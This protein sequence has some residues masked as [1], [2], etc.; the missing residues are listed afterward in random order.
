MVGAALKGVALGH[1][2][3]VISG[4]ECLLTLLGGTM[5]PGIRLDL[6]AGAALDI[7]IAHRL[8]GR[9]SV[10]DLFLRDRLEQGVVALVGIGSPQ[11]CVAVS[12]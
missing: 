2:A 12:L 1:F 3:R 7:V 8:G 5:R 4:E 9:D 10:R 6:S 11:A